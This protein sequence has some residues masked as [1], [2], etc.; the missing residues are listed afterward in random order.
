MT[1]VTI[2]AASTSPTNLVN[3]LT[4][5]PA[6][7][8]VAF[9]APPFIPTDPEL[10]F[11]LL[12]RG[13]DASGITVEATKYS[14]LCSS[15][16]V[17]YAKEI[18][19]LIARPPADTPYTKTKAELLK[20]L[21]V[22]QEEKT[23]KLLETQVLGDQK[24]S[25]FLR[26]LRE[27]AGG[28][29]NESVLRTLWL[30]NLPA[31]VQQILTIQRDKPLDDNAELAD[32]IMETI[33]ATQPFATPQPF[34]APQV[35]AVATTPQ[36]APS[37]YDSLESMF[38]QVCAVNAEMRH[39]ISEIRRDL[40]EERT[41]RSRSQSQGR[42]TTRGRSQS[43]TRADNPNHCWY[44]Q[45]FGASATKCRQPCTYAGNGAGTR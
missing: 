23:R 29:I 17:Q 18:R 36:P 40:Q 21:N 9:R 41:R 26:Q 45:R 31:Q 11:D 5:T 35:A 4:M 3:G 1:G 19:D 25:Q 15:L 34:V 37:Q 10:W 7:E 20:R 39:E 32:A 16:G 38:R 44:H 24:P 6:I 30:R 43:R 22:S 14:H 42:P 8:R 12:E 28:A 27:L 13:F 33:R 2:P